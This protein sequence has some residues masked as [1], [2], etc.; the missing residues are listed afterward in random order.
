MK[1]CEKLK[2]NK[3]QPVSVPRN[4][5]LYARVGGR[6]PSLG[7]SG[8]TAELSK[9]KLDIINDSESALLE[10]MEKAQPK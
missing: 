1:V 10:E 9:S 2:L 8:F 6:V 7:T 3:F 5:D 4:K